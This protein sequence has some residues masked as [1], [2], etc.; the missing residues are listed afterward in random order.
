YKRLT[1]RYEA[2]VLTGKGLSWGG[3]L[4][5]TEATGYGLVFFVQ[6]MLEANNKSLSGS[7]V[8]VSGSGNVAIY[9]TEKVHELGGRV[10]GTSDSSG[11]IYDPAGIDI[12]LLKE[13]KEVRRARIE[14]Y[15]KERGNGS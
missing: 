4:A 2:G 9:A 5:R 7:T 14:E 1:N 13:I 11:S 3:S 8:L 6:R 10:V 12:A 15:V